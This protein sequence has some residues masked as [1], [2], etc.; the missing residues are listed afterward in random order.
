MPR[1]YKREQPFPS[2]LTEHPAERN[3]NISKRFPDTSL[4]ESNVFNLRSKR[5]IVFEEYDRT[6]GY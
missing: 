4:S 5:E 3:R 1:M 6:M 2:L